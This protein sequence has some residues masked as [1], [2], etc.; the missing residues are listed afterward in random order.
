MLSVNVDTEQGIS[1]FLYRFKDRTAYQRRSKAAK[2]ADAC[3]D[4]GR[5]YEI[6][7]VNVAVRYVKQILAGTCVGN[8]EHNGEYYDKPPGFRH[9]KDVD[10][11]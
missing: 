4:G 5:F 6:L 11:E 2:S 7:A 9:G 1:V 3:L 10:K 8:V